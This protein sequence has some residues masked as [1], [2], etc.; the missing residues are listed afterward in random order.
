MM[1][2]ELRQLEHGQTGEKDRGDALDADDSAPLCD[3]AENPATAREPSHAPAPVTER[4]GGLRVPLKWM[5][6]AASFGLAMDQNLM[7]RCSALLELAL[8]VCTLLI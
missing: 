2:L 3:H 7:V 5:I 6:G 8:V 4:R 1:S